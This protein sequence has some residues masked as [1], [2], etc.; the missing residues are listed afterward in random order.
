VKS[1]FLFLFFLLSYTANVLPQTT[2]Y[3]YKNHKLI[4]KVLHDYHSGLY[5]DFL[6]TIHKIYQQEKTKHHIALEERKKLAI[7]VQKVNWGQSESLKTKMFNLF[8][9]QERELTNIY[10]NHPDDVFSREVRDMIFFVLSPKEQESFE[11]LHALSYK[12]NGDGETP[13]ENKLISIDIEFWLKEFYLNIE[14]ARKKHD[15]LTY[16]KQHIV[17]Q[18]E[19]LRRMKQEC[20]KD[21]CGNTKIHTFITNAC[22]LIPKIQASS[23]THNHLIALGLGEIKPKNFVEK[24]IQDTVIRFISKRRILIEKHFSDNTMILFSE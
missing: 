5:D 11:Y 23:A 13:L 20:D 16:Q 15:P 19:K 22:D 18:L 10:I 12:F 24:K 2:E 14:R 21:K 4:D 3:Q 7:T 8:E 17:L 9:E 1:F 6:K